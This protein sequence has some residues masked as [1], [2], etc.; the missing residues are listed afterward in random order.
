MIMSRCSDINLVFLLAALSLLLAGNDAMA[1]LEARFTIIEK[2]KDFELRRYEP[3]IVAQ[4]AVEGDFTDAG[5]TGFR[6]LF[7]YINGKN[8]KNVPIPMTAPVLE[9]TA[10]QKIPT[11]APVNQE[12]ENGKWVISFV[13]LQDYTLETLPEPL[14]R[15]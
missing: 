12:K 10:S 4:T 6:R 13:M 9:E 11:T 1:T 8:R 3:Q 15:E 5:N 2:E 14:I 7:D